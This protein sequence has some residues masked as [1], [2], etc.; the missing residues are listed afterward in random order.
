[1]IKKGQCLPGSVGR[2]C[3]SWSKG[4]ELEP[5]FGDRLYLKGKKAYLTS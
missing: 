5:H 1:M 2:A 4:Y 3:D